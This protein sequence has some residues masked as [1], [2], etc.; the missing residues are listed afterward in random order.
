MISFRMQNINSDYK[1]YLVTLVYGVM[2]VW[3]VVGKNLV[4]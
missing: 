3:M 4:G 2:V 1:Q